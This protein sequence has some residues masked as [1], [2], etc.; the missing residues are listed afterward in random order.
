M[1]IEFNTHVNVRVNGQPGTTDFREESHHTVAF[2]VCGEG[3]LWLNR[4]KGGK[5]ELFAYV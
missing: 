3:G 2:H 5:R 1:G 4:N